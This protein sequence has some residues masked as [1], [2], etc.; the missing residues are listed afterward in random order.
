M[1]C[2]I[3]PIAEFITSPAAAFV[4]EHLTKPCS[5]FQGKLDAWLVGSL[6]PTDEDGH[7]ALVEDHGEIVGWARTEQWSAGSD[8]A[9]GLVLYD[10]L[11]AFVAPPY[12]R[13]GIAAFAATGLYAAVL[14][15][16]PPRVV[17]FH[18][19]MLLVAR[20]AGFWP[21]LFQKEGGQWF[22]VK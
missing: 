18:P 21:T 11:E 2:T 16:T 8:G 4:R 5:D 10:T 20:R 15:D 12:R 13:R 3:L 1:T 17:V 14:L 6:T 19:H 9:G 7:I 22:R